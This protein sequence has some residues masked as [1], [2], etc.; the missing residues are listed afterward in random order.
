MGFHYVALVC[1]ELLGSSNPTTLASQS[2][3]ITVMSH[4]VWPD[5]ILLHVILRLSLALSPR[6]ECSGTIS[7]HNLCLPDSS[8]SPA[9]A[10]QILGFTILARLS[11]TPDL[12]FHLWLPPK[13]KYTT[14][15]TGSDYVAQADLKLLVSTDPPVLASQSA[16]ITGVSH[17][18]QPIKVFYK[19][20]VIQK[21]NT[22]SYSVTQAGVQWRDLSS[23]QPP[24]PWFKQFP[25]ISFRSS[26][27]YS[28]DRVSP[29]W[30]GWSRSLDLVIHSPQPP[31][32]LGLQARDEVSPCWPGWS[33][34]LDLMICLPQPP[35]VLGLQA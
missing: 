22:E 27:D 9:S 12:V 1:L 20:L 16:K 6:Q 29:C 17:C 24:P 13:L 35:K 19:F 3:G 33:R 11:R 31:K 10:S 8:N 30:P 23:L 14:T 4:C 2:A 34:S 18:A 25:C 7:A 28:R 26:W 32:V 21:K 5:R 15:E